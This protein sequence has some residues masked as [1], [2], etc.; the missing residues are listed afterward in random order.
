MTAPAG[1]YPDPSG[2]PMQRYFDGRAWTEHY[3]PQASAP[4]TPWSFGPT[5]YAPQYNSAPQG[6]PRSFPTRF[7]N[8][9]WIVIAVVG[10]AV[11]GIAVLIATDRDDNS[12]QAGRSYGATFASSVSV[13]SSDR[14]SETQIEV[15][16]ATGASLA[17]DRDVYYW[18]N[19]QIKGSDIDKDDFKEGCIDSAKD[20]F[21]SR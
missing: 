10:A 8:K 19:G 13:L 16:C 14:I 4:A 17:H 20:G 12:Y 15:S 18:P 7:P 5:H 2:K 1:W 9:Q 3:A 11:L 21:G 6:S